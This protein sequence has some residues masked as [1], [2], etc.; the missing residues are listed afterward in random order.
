MC[1]SIHM[2]DSMYVYV[3][4]SIITV[5]V[6]KIHR[7]SFKIMTKSSYK[8][9]KHIIGQQKSNKKWHTKARKRHENVVRHKHKVVR[10]HRHSPINGA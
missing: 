7:E 8:V 10:T 4:V 1:T 5:F 3:S 6:E 9:G 2:C